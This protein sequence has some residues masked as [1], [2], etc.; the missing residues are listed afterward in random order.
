MGFFT[1]AAVNMDLIIGI[2]AV[3]GWVIAQAL[4]NKKNPSPPSRPRPPPS[5]GPGDMINP[6]DDLRK[7]FQD[8]ERGLTGQGERTERFNA[9]GSLAT[10]KARAVAQP[11]G[12]TSQGT[13]S[14]TR[15]SGTSQTNN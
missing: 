11:D 4:G 8:L 1:V 15:K 6:N 2:M 3:V 10:Q 14:H 7:F 13:P 12:T 9:H 5:T